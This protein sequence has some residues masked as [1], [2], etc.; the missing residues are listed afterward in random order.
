M[1]KTLLIAAAVLGIS[2]SAQAGPNPYVGEVQVLPYNFCPSGFL[3]ADGRTVL[4]ND[5]QA[6]YDLYG[7]TYGGDGTTTFALPYLALKPA[8]H[9]ATMKVCIAT[10]GIFPPTN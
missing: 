7:T 6:L 10:E 2:A 4:I 9:K 8:G 5:Y 1:R 3:P